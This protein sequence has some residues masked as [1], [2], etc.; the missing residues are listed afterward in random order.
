MR[1]FAITG[2]VTASWMSLMT[3]GLAIRAPPPSARILFF[4]AE[5]G[6]RDSSVTG[7]QTCARPIYI[8][9]GNGIVLSAVMLAV[10]WPVGWR[11]KCRSEERRGGKEC[12]SRISR[13]HY[14]KK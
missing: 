4:P 12:R 6:I 11:T 1:A 10:V 9:Y 5:D 8:S 2:I 13:F 3:L 7:V 14:T